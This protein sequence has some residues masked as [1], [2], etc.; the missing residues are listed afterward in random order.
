MAEISLAEI[1]NS[2]GILIASEFDAFDPKD[3]E[4]FPLYRGDGLLFKFDGLDDL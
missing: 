1:D 4:G 2:Q 3:I